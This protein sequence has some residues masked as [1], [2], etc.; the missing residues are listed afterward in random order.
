MSDEIAPDDTVWVSSK[1]G[2]TAT[3]EKCLHVDPDCR[4]LSRA[5]NVLEKQRSMYAADQPVC[6]I[7]TGEYQGHSNASRSEAYQ[8]LKEVADE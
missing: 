8:I 3:S 5:A 1:F 7:C 2:G 4:A 6:D